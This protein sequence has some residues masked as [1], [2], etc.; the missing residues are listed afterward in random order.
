[1]EVL[2][3]H[4]GKDRAIS[5]AILARKLQIPRRKVR[6]LIAELVDAGNLIGASVDG[7]DGGYFWIQTKRE[8]EEARA[9]LRARATK[10]FAR[11]RALRQSWEREHGG[12]TLPLLPEL[13]AEGVL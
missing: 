6:A 12:V 3:A 13:V 2:L 10:I 8:L 7:V 4:K 11:D 1:L 5:S 9:I